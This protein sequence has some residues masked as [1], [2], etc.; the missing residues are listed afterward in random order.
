[1]KT[2]FTFDRSVCIRTPVR[3][4]NGITLH[5]FLDQSGQV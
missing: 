1:M 3:V 5:A 4:L 2:I